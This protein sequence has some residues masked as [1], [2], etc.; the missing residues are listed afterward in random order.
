MSILWRNL[1]N[2]RKL[3]EIRIRLIVDRVLDNRKVHLD[4]TTVRQT[5]WFYHVNH[6]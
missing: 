1:K 3:I 4:I 6:V 5:Q 2:I